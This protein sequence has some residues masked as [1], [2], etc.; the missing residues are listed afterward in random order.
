MSDPEKIVR[1]N[2]NVVGGSKSIIQEG[3]N[4]IATILEK[5]SMADFTS[6]KLSEP[7]YGDVEIGVLTD[8]ECI[9]FARFHTVTMRHK[10]ISREVGGAQIEKI[11]A[12]IRTGEIDPEK[13]PV[14]GEI[15]LDHDLLKEYFRILSFLDYSRAAF[16]HTI[17]LRIPGNWEYK[18]G[19]RTKRRIFRAQRRY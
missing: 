9:L 3:D 18:L 17:Q 8:E 19:V 15:F 14:D 6:L 16:T 10:E 5:V 1:P 12:G 11:G 13:G 4:D 2:F 7:K